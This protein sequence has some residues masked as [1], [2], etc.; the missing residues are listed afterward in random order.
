MKPVKKIAKKHTFEY[1]RL[2]Y[3]IRFLGDAFFYTFLYVFLASLGFSTA[4]LGL[5]AALSPFAA[6]TGNIIF[7]RIAKNLEVNRILMFIFA[8]V[9]TSVAIIF[10]LIQKQPFVFYAILIT[11][12]SF[13]NGPF[14]S[15]LDGYS[16]TYISERNKQYSSMR[17]MG[18]LSY[19][20]GPL[21]GGILADNTAGGFQSLFIMS[22]LFFLITAFLIYHLPKQKIELFIIVP[23]EERTK[24]KIIGKPELIAYLL[25]NF[26]V[27]G[28]MVVSDNFFGIYL[29]NELGVSTTHFG[30]VVS[31]AL[32]IEASTMF[33]ISLRKNI[34]F[35]VPALSFLIVG[36]FVITRPI[37]V[38]LNL[39]KTW[40]LAL[41]VIRGVG[42]GYYIV[43]NVRF[44]ARV[45]PLKHLTKALL[46]GSIATTSGRIITS[47][48]MGEALKHYSYSTVFLVVIFVVIFGM[49]LS[50]TIAEIDRRKQK[51]VDMIVPFIEPDEDLN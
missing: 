26:F 18:T 9:E 20:I 8:L 7:Q 3:F 25:F 46:T 33:F 40:I 45:V 37:I 24:L 34:S 47:L 13:I 5:V 50:M 43:F 23:P 4:Q 41:S 49:T 51:K 17:I 6:L 21:I 1:L 35:R 15:L 44:L 28:V 36:S 14:Y 12:V 30:Y 48:I 16:G 2:T 11:C 27:I 10:V 31:A 22:S 39:P 29:R 32:I 19:V 42:W 38:A